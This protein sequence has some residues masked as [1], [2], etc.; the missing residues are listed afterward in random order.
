MNNLIKSVG[1]FPTYEPHINIKNLSA[2]Y[3]SPA[4]RFRYTLL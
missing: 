1:G 3:A 4:E 2:G